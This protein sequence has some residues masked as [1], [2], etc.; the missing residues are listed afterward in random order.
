[1]SLPTSI[2]ID[3]IPQSID[4]FVALRDQVATTPQGG[5]AM[6]VVALIAYATDEELGRQCLTVAVD[7]DRLQEGAQGYKGWELRRSDLQ[8]IRLQLQGK[9][10]LAY[11]YLQGTSPQNGYQPSDPPYILTFQDNPYS[12]DVDSGTYKTFVHS[13]GAD[14]PRPVTL[15]RNNRGVW[16]AS[17]WSSLIVGVAPP[18]KKADDDL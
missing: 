9:A 3:G 1:M 15:K 11:S 6:M 5:A 7:R 17:E 14:S 2:Q 8:R 16:K 12:G 18:A 4:A 10:Y 13:S